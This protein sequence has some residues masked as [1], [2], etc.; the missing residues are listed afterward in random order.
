MNTSDY[1]FMFQ[2]EFKCFAEHYNEFVNVAI[3]MIAEVEEED[4]IDSIV[5]DNIKMDIT[6]EVVEV[7]F[8]YTYDDDER[9]ADL[10]FSEFNK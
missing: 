4:D 9:I 2:T 7:T 8:H 3:N 1:K 6:D 5:I 10:A